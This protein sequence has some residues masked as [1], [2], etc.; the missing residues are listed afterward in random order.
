[1]KDEPTNYPLAWPS[2]FKR[3]SSW[4]RTESRFKNDRRRLTV[5]DGVDRVLEAIAKFTKGRSVYR[6]D[7]DKAIISTNVQPKLGGRP[8][9]SQREPEDTGVAVYFTLDKKPIVICADKYDSVADNLAAVAATIEALQAIERHGATEAE[10]AF[11]GFMALPEKAAARTFYDV[12]GIPRNQPLSQAVIDARWK[13][14]AKT[15]H[16]DLPGGS[17]DAFTEL[18]DARHQ[19][20]TA[21]RS[22]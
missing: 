21:L 4:Q 17:H 22:A 20:M 19:A 18:N 6:A 9:S 3:R 11:T 2:G 15:C 14:M 1:M 8:M 7:P 16:P 12:L 10:R 5:A 13:E